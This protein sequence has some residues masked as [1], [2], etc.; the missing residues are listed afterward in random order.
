MSQHNKVNNVIWILML[1]YFTSKKL[2]VFSC[3]PTAQMVVAIK[4]LKHWISTLQIENNKANQKYLNEPFIMC[5]KANIWCV[6][7]PIISWQLRVTQLHV[8]IKQNK[9]LVWSFIFFVLC[10]LSLYF[11][12]TIWQFWLLNYALI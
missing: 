7:S 10:K 2:I 4:C 3:V 12:N 5:Y 11:I 9:L 8:L 6:F 1:V